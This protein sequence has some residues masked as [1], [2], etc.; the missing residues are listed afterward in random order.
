MENVKDVKYD[1]KKELYKVK[2][3]LKK[4]SVVG[5][6]KLTYDNKE[7]NYDLIIKE[8]IEKASFIRVL[9]SILSD[10]ISGVKIK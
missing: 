10:L 4:N 5:K 1:I 7:Y 8:N 9:N 3:P 6:I 2:A